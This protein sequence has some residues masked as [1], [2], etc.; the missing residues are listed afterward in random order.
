M[1]DPVINT[2]FS[3]S[4]SKE[5]E[6]R[7]ESIKW[8]QVNTRYEIYVPILK[9]LELNELVPHALNFRSKVLTTVGTAAHK[10]PSLCEAFPRSMTLVL[11]S[12]WE[13]INADADADPNMDNAQTIDN[14]N[15]RLREFIAV[16]SVEEDRHELVQFLRKARKP[17][18]LSVQTFWY[19]LRE[20]NSYVDWLPGV[21]PPLNNQQMR[22]A[23]HDGMPPTWRERF[24]NAGNSVATMTMAQVVQYFRKQE[25]QAT[26]K[27]MDNNRQQKR[28]SLANKKT[29]GA[30]RPNGKAS[31]G[32]NET[33]S[34]GKRSRIQADDPCPVHPGLGHKWGE[35]RANAY[36]KDRDQTKRPKGASGSQDANMAQVDST[37]FNEGTNAPMKALNDDLSD[38]GTFECHCYVN[39]EE[40]ISQHEWDSISFTAEQV[41]PK[42]EFAFD[43]SFTSLCEDAYSLGDSDITIKTYMDVT[44]NLRLRSIS[45]MT[46]G[47]VQNVPNSRPLKV[48]FDTGSDKTM[49]NIRI[50]PKGAHAKTVTGTRVT[51][52]H[53]G[54]LL[55]QEVLLSDIG[56][57][58][59]SPTQR[60]PGPIRATIFTNPES[61]YDIILGMDVMQ[62]LGIDINCSTKTVTWNQNMI[63]FR[64]AN[65]F[66]RATFSLTSSFDEDDPLLVEAANQAGYKSKTILHSKY[67]QVSPKEVAEKQ[68]HLT[69]KQQKDLETLFSKYQKLF[70]G[71]L[72]KYPNRKVQLELKEGAK[73]YTCRPFPVPRKHEQVFKDEL[74]RLV[75]EGVLTPCGAS[76]WLFPTFLIPKKDG[77][78]RWISDFRELN[79]VIKR[80]VYNLPKIQEILNRRKGY[81]YFSKIDVSMHY[82]TFELDEEARNLCTI[83]TPFGNYRY[84]RL[85]MGV[86]Q[87]PDI[88]QEVMEDLFRALEQTDVY[89]D[90]VGVFDNSWEEHL[91]SLDKSLSIL[92]E[93]NFTVNPLKC[94]WGVQE[95]DW[96]GYWLTPNGLKPWKKKVEAILAINRP[97]T[98][99]QLRSFLGAVNFY[100]D[101]YP[102]RSHILAP[103]TKMSGLKGKIPWDDECQRAFDQMKALLAKE[104]FLAF[105][106]HNQPFHIYVDASDVQLG[107][108]IFQ[109]GKPVAFYSRKLNAAQ[110]NYTVGEKELLSAVET[111]KEFRNMLYGCADIT[112]YTDHKNNTF[113]TIHTQRVIRWRLFLEDFGVK[114]SY[115]K[116]GDN[117]LADALSRLPFTEYHHEDSPRPSSSRQE[118]DNSIDSFYSMAIDDDDLLDCCL[119]LP[120]DKEI[121]FVLGYQTLR[122]AQ[123][124]DARLHA[125]LQK[126]PDRF[127]KQLLAADVQL[128]CYIPEPNAPWKIY[129]PTSLLDDAIQWYHLS[130]GHLGQNRLYDTLHQQFYHPDL[131]SYVEKIVTTCDAC[132]RQ[133]NPLRG[134]GHVAAREVTLLPWR[135]VA[136]DLIGPWK[137]QINNVEVNF[138][139]LTIIDLVTNIVEL[140]RLDN[141]TSAHV[142]LQF[143]NTWL[144]R[145]PMP[146]HCVYDQGGEFVGFPFQHMLE[147]HGIRGHPTTAKN[148]QAN[149]ICERM[150]QT[151]GNSLRAM[152]VMQPPAGIDS[153]N[154]LVD[155]ALANCMFA[156]RAALHSGLQASPGSLAFNRDMIL[157]IPFVADWMLIQERRQQLVDSKL[158]AANRKRFNHDYRVGDLV[159]KLAYKP[160][161]LQSRADGG[162]YRVDSVHTNGTVTIRLSPHTTERISIRRIKPYKAPLPP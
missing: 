120:T 149:A 71:K 27:M 108:A 36:N 107:A 81:K 56:F 97:T 3:F 118:M 69:K 38:Q 122:D 135:E 24:S 130:L 124:G 58:E 160:D 51:G 133:K 104:A 94:E 106:D 137:L 65:Y 43:E 148:P 98:A 45:I 147:R 99:K 132:Q 1:N 55:N 115:I 143:E 60:I 141:K 89:I 86:S 146:K 7:T 50:L 79:K 39:Q 35:C 23:F 145:Y 142:A 14:F 128:Y 48:L 33:N 10:G 155:T 19:K 158:L 78:V 101:M 95:T 75:S 123:V 9:S 30:S 40:I 4:P 140:V 61:N 116:G 126:H 162:P 34:N 87:S 91:A 92:Q 28:Q 117:T 80:K 72:G 144:S 31:N 29:K 59:F 25:A 18:A 150:H 70:S 8:T 157:D 57:P 96:L 105:P 161:K 54:K 151:V 85:P 6:Q 46:V 15:A 156:T 2:S 22:Q 83:C 76:E 100:R 134:H 67:E 20:F 44:Q 21:E 77:R 5:E 88:A 64:P 11:S 52:V 110:K 68:Q 74:N 63:P 84:N 37:P 16:H 103:L 47:L 153:A 125:L 13:Q 138:R 32:S 73:P 12:V 121:P 111:L 26:K 90:D 136:V 17:L 152:I 82:Y 127:S 102:R 159:L 62:V 129:L 112:I 113:Q 93:H 109:N 139:A 49:A 42:G 119:N 53:G 41:R 66:E 114:L 131:R 154:R